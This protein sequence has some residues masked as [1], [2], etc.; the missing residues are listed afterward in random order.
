MKQLTPVQKHFLLSLLQ[1]M[2]DTGGPVST[3][4]IRQ[5]HGKS[6]SGVRSHIRRM[7]EGGYITCVGKFSQKKMFVS[8]QKG[9]DAVADEIQ[10]N[11]ILSIMDTVDSFCIGGQCQTVGCEHPA[12]DFYRD[13]FYCRR[14]IIGYDEDDDIRDIRRYH[15]G[16]WGVGSIAGQVLEAAT[17]L[18]SED[19][20]ASGDELLDVGD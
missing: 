5:L 1:A 19:S 8:T 7:T 2:S 16:R 17:P 6:D 14:C 18:N 20:I 4:D 15:E 11:P 10:G 12:E 13:G 9:M 3:S